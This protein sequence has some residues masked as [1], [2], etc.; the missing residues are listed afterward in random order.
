MVNSIIINCTIRILINLKIFII[1][2]LFD[3]IFL[4]RED[5][6]HTVPSKKTSSNIIYDS[7]DINFQNR[8][9]RYPFK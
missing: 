7:A 2:L 4:F 8:R 6:K 5:L 1:L 3:I 9:L